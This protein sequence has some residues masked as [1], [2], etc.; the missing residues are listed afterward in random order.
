M[1][2]GHQRALVR[3]VAP[4]FEPVSVAEAKQ[5][6]RVEHTHDDRLIA[7]LIVAARMHAEDYMRISLLSQTWKLVIGSEDAAGGVELPRGPVQS[8]SSVAIRLADNSELTLASEHYHYEQAA[9]RLCIHT[10]YTGASTE[11]S[12]VCGYGDVLAIP[13]AIRLGILSHVAV[14]YDS[15]GDIPADAQEK[16][17]AAYYAA[18]R[19]VA[20]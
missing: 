19:K 14:L 5:Y 3:V 2:K 20:I 9:G 10:S 1:T 4:A 16:L 17:C 18:H 6:I 7:D 12:Y 13:A 11:I 8:I 15:R